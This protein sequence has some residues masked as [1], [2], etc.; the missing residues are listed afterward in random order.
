M[1][2]IQEKTQIIRIDRLTSDILRF[3]LDAPSIASV[4][5]PGQF[6]M[7]RTGETNDPQL[8]NLG[9]LGVQAPWNNGSYA[10]GGNFAPQLGSDKKINTVDARMENMIFRNGKLWTTHHVYLPAGNPFHVSKQCMIADVPSHSGHIRKQHCEVQKW[11]TI[12][13]S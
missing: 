12:L 5:T 13:S 6:V 7:I 9:L 10:N 3:T 1:S 8:V 4:A 2:Q 11:F